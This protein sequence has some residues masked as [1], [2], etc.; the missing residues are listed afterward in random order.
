[1]Q[2]IVSRGHSRPLAELTFV[3]ECDNASLL[4]SAAHD[5]L[6]QIRNGETGDWIGSFSGHKGAVWS[7]KVDKL[8]RTLA[9]TGSGDFTAKLW[10][11]TT[12][13]EL[14]EYKHRHVVKSVDF[15]HDT[16]KFVTGSQDGSIRVFDTA[17]PEKQ[18][19]TIV[20]TPSATSSGGSGTSSPS[21]TDAVSR[22]HWGHDNN[23]ILIGRRSGVV[24]LWDIRCQGDNHNKPSLST[25][26]TEGSPIMDIEL[27]TDHNNIW[28]AS[29]KQVIVLNMKDISKM[30]SYDMPTGMHFNEEGGVSLHPS[31]NKFAAGASDLWLREFD[32]QSGEVLRTL[33]G[34][35]GPIRCVRYHPKGHLVATGSED[36]TIRLWST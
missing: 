36:A 11:A 22:V 30:R 33:K 18:P 24:Q 15:S 3:K 21:L 34:H 16:L 9:V 8:T 28:I 23:T 6:P 12:G 4:V 31:G 7:T 35:H 17:T 1:M 10:C 14:Q 20:S 2:H 29:G 32:V 19:L 25:Q 13:K 5:K 27:N 26:V